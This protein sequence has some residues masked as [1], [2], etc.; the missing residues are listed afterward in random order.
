MS[1]LEHKPISIQKFVFLK[2]EFSCEIK[3]RHPLISVEKERYQSV[4]ELLKAYPDLT[5]IENLNQLAYVVNFLSA[6]VDYQLIEDI[7][8]FQEKYL[9]QVDF[10]KNSYDY[11]PQRITDHGIFDITGMTGPRMIDQTLVF[12]VRSTHNGLPYCVRFPLPFDGNTLAQ[13]QLLPYA[14]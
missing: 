13:Y 5:R 12:Y 6:G 2:Q 4:C 10:E 14:E 3:D 7:V 1:K 8:T 11:L 9:A